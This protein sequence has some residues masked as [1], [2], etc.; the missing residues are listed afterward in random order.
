MGHRGRAELTYCF[1]KADICATPSVRQE[2]AELNKVL[3]ISHTAQCLQWEE[4]RSPAISPSA[5]FCSFVQPSFGAS[6][7]FSLLI[8]A[9][10][11]PILPVATYVL[12]GL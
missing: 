10:G 12:S 1:L 6:V 3:V 8:A 7:A 4:R 2:K 11:T 9:P 5:S